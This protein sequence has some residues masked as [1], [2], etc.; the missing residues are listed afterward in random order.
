MRLESMTWGEVEGKTGSRFVEVTA[1]EGDAQR[2]LVEIGK[3][4]QA[5]LFSLRIT[6]RIRLWGIRDIAILRVLWW[7]P[8]HS[9]C[10]SLKK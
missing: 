2:R 6:G 8:E 10:P 7:D 4:E 3:D 9:V 5:R 1:I